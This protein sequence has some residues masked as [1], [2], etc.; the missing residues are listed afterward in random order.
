MNPRRVKDRRTQPR[1][2]INPK[3]ATSIANFFDEEGV[4]F[5][6]TTDDVGDP[7]IKAKADGFADRADSA[8][9]ETTPGGPSCGLNSRSRDGGGPLLD[10]FEKRVEDAR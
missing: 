2:S 1:P 7:K 5:E 10:L 4:S 3:N 6:V 8:E 9:P